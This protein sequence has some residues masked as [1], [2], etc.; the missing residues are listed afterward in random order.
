M[1]MYLIYLHA[2]NIMLFKLPFSKEEYTHTK[3]FTAVLLDLVSSPVS[4]SPFF[5]IIIVISPCKRVHI[6]YT[7]TVGGMEPGVMLK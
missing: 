2:Y 5:G 7:D 6:V 1:Y 4:S 3:Q